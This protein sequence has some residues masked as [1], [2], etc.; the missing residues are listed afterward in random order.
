MVS[1]LLLHAILIEKNYTTCPF[2][3]ICRP[4]TLK[5]F[6]NNYFYQSI[7]KKLFSPFQVCSNVAVTEG[8]LPPN[9][10]VCY[11]FNIISQ[12]TMKTGELIKQTKQT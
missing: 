12:K 2:T 10:G 1:L 9:F 8:L 3:D 7:L 6:Y 4:E 11:I 5:Q